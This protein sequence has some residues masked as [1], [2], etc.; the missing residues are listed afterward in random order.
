MVSPVRDQ[1]VNAALDRFHAL[2]Y[3]ACGVQDI[4]DKAGVPKGSFYNYFK[5]KELLALEVVDLYAKGSKRE[6]LSDAGV[7][8][9]ERLRGHFEFL[10]SRYAGFGYDK[11]CLLG[12]LAAEAS[13]GMPLL[14][15]ALGE[16]LARW[17]A[18][19][20]AVIKEGQAQGTIASEIDAEELA[21]F[22]VNSWEGAVVRMKIVNSRR[23][24]DDFFAIAFPLLGA[25]KQK[26][27]NTG[28][29]RKTSVKSRKT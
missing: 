20:A 16:S 6:M 14:R 24:L 26:P 25:L 21:R 22:L 2:G 27:R 13:D 3:S 11:G 12:N 7:A 5:A 8:P 10:A 23:P 19:V 28:G 9:V 1:I 17:T 4:V 15:K 29:K 18:A